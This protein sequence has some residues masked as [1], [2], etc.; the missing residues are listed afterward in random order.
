MSSMYSTDV[1][2]KRAGY[3]AVQYQ[4]QPSAVEWENGVV[5]G[6]VTLV[7]HCRVPPAVLVGHNC[8]A[9]SPLQDGQGIRDAAHRRP[10]ARR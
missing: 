1:L 3:R 6:R 7:M 5:A 8:R 9:R 10:A 2:G 4:V